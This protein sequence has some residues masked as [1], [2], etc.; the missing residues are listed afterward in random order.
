VKPHFI[1]GS[2]LDC[3]AGHGGEAMTGDDFV[4]VVQNMLQI[5]TAPAHTLIVFMSSEQVLVP[6]PPSPSTIANRL[7]QQ[8]SDNLSILKGYPHFGIPSKP[9]QNSTK[10][11]ISIC[12]TTSCKIPEFFTKYRKINFL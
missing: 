2:F 5:T 9:Y 4:H 7:I 12:F 3:G 8:S 1:V 6:P 10:Y 11:S